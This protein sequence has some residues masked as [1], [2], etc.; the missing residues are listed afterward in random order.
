MIDK[1][2]YIV[3]KF[4]YFIMFGGVIDNY[5]NQGWITDLNTLYSLNTVLKE[6][7]KH[8]YI[9]S[10]VKERLYNFLSVSRSIK[11]ENYDQR[12]EII[13]NIISVLNCQ[14]ND[15]SDEFYYFEMLKRFRNIFLLDEETKKQIDES[16]VYDF[17]IINLHNL[18]P[19]SFNEYI[20]D[21]SSRPFEYAL[22]LNAILAENESLFQDKNFN[23][24]VN[25]VLSLIEKDC[26]YPQNK[27]ISKKYKK[28]IKKL[29]NS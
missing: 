21:F 16:I 27:K 24:N 6:L 17:A 18:E 12:I 1:Q 29:G 25:C 19:S 23:E 28:I 2:E 7:S 9:P 13:N 8:N 20:N 5:E 15:N 26:S 10:K 4:I 22:S 11:T 3:E 14:I